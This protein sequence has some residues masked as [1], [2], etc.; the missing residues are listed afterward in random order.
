[1]A[2]EGLRNAPRPSEV[3]MSDH[4]GASVEALNVIGLVEDRDQVTESVTTEY[5][6]L[7]QS[8]RTGEAF[9]QLPRGI[10]TLADL[11]KAL[12]SATYPGD[13]LYPETYVY[14]E[15]WTPGFDKG[16][17]EAEELD[18]LTLGGDGNFA[19]HAR[20]AVHNPASVQEPLLHFLDKP[21][22]KE[23]AKRGQHRNQLS[24]GNREAIIRLWILKR[25][26]PGRTGFSSGS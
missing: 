22:D 2:I 15:L 14:E 25:H 21:F 24:Y 13:R 18:N 5:R 23:Y 17:Y 3:N 16:G 26:L 1:M 10:I 11:V 8:G 4:V 6:A 7:S 9:I 19:P 12:D 20:L